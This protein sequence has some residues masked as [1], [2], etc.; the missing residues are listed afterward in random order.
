MKSSLPR[1]PG[2]VA[3]FACLALSACNDKDPAPLF[4]DMAY[5][6]RCVD[7]TPRANHDPIRDIETL[8]EESGFSVRCVA[9]R[10]ENGERILTFE[11]HFSDPEGKADSYSIRVDRANLDA[12]GPGNSCS[13]TVVEDANTYE[14]GCTG[15]ETGGKTPCQVILS[16]EGGIVEGS[17][18]CTDIPNANNGMLSRHVTKP[19]SNDAPAHFVVHGCE[20]I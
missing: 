12:N 6:V 7:C 15:G 20:D 13:V 11:T 5:Q 1:P 14:G 9:T 18:L 19:L 8:D 16:E 4:F 3:L 10:Q 17:L 2:F